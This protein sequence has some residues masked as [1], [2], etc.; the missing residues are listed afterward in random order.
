MLLIFNETV[1]VVEIVVMGV[2]CYFLTCESRYGV[3]FLLLI[4]NESF[5]ALPLSSPLSPLLLLLLR[6]EKPSP[7]LGFSSSLLRLA[8]MAWRACLVGPAISSHTHKHSSPRHKAQLKH[9]TTQV[10]DIDIGHACSTKWHNTQ[11]HV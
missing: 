2:F 9:L 3:F 4:F 8:N 1:G 7:S 6:W 11:I 10:Y 5:S